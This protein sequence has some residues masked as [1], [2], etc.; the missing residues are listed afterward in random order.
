[1][2]VSNSLGIKDQAVLNIDVADYGSL[3]GGNMAYG[4]SL[5][6]SDQSTVT[7]LNIPTPT[8]ASAPR[9]R[10]SGNTVLEFDD[11]TTMTGAEL[12][13]LLK[14]LE[15]IIAKDYPEELL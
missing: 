9:L 2:S 6:W 13:R 10:V 1:M 4:H 15:N 11:G 8:W 3:A 14:A 12:H 5:K 7:S